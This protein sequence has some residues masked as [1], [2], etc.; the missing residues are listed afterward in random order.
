MS[1]R[2]VSAIAARRQLLNPKIVRSPVWALVARKTYATA[3]PLGT[4]HSQSPAATPSLR[5]FWK[6][7]DVKEVE[8]GYYVTLDGRNMKTPEGR[9]L[10]IPKEKRLLALL[11]AGEWES[12]DTLLKSYSLPLTSVVVR[13]I[14]AF[15]DPETRK[16]VIDTLLRYLNGDST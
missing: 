11:I 16:G 1:I 10:L 9:P 8:G 5:R 3:A 15:H 6:K 4:T 13:S 12:Q 2:L 7:V 14:D